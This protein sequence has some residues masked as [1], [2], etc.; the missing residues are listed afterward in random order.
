[1]LSGGFLRRR[2]GPKPFGCEAYV[3]TQVRFGK[4]RERIFEDFVTRKSPDMLPK[5]PPGTN[6][7]Q[8]ARKSGA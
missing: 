5:R 6:S 8:T 3:P 7:C 2:P 1:M 4:P